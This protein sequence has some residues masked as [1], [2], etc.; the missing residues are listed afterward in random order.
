MGNKDMD[1]VYTI[2]K[3]ENVVTENERMD[4]IIECLKI[5]QEGLKDVVII[6]ENK[7]K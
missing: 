5:I 2:C 1:C 7:P 3:K 6:L 4:K